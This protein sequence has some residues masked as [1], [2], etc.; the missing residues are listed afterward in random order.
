MLRKVALTN[1]KAFERFTMTLPGDAFLVGPNNAGKSTLI[2]AIRLG[3]SLLR[4]ATARTPSLPLRRPGISGVV[5]PLLSDQT[6]FV[7][8]NIRH[9]FHNLETRL[10]L[11]FSNGGHLIAVWPEAASDETDDDREPDPYFFLRVDDRSQPLTT[12]AVKE[13]FPAVGVI[14]MLTP[15]EHDEILL[16]E[17]YIKRNQD[18]RL[19]SRHFR[20][21]LHLMRNEYSRTHQS[22]MHEFLDFAAEWVPE[23]EIGD[24]VRRPSK[25]GFQLDVFYTEPG[26]RAEKELYWSGDGIQVWLQLLLHVFRVRDMATVVI[27]EPDVFLHADLQ[28]RLVRLLEAVTPQTITATHS[29]EM[30][31]EASVENVIWVD[32]TRRRAVRGPTASVMSD[33][34]E[35]IGSQFNI[36]LAKALRSK[37]CL[38]VEGKD[39][40]IVRYLARAVG[41]A[42]LST[43]T[44]VAVVPLE[45]FSNWEHVEPFGWLVRNLLE[46][47]V[48]T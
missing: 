33:L 46:G 13:A 22:R 35:A 41:A 40:K 2:S 48:T 12:K 42:R 39:M 14:P 38:F 44:G 29:P 28:R 47:S 4:Y 11:T 15:L 37:V 16:D 20:N 25:D 3:A 30:L 18:G 17:R 21:H 32:K 9:E 45:G 26:F 7:E 5:Y 43:E 6:V 31:A 34:S 36:R 23:L 27:D 8:E 10:E 24:L 19:A 1:F